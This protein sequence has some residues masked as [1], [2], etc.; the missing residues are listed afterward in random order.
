MLLIEHP[1]L[2]TT[3]SREARWLRDEVLGLC[4]KYGTVNVKYEEFTSKLIEQYS[5]IPWERA[6]L[7]V[8]AKEA[9]K[10][11]CRRTS[12]AFYTK[13]SKKAG[14]DKPTW[15]RG[16]VKGNRQK[17]VNWLR[18][19]KFDFDHDWWNEVIG[20]KRNG[21]VLPIHFDRVHNEFVEMYTLITKW[22]ITDFSTKALFRIF[23]FTNKYS[24]DLISKCM[25]L[26]EDPSKRS[27]EYLVPIIE[28]EFTIAKN[29]LM[30]R[31]EL[32]SQSKQILTSILETVVSEREAVDWD[33]VEESIQV[34]TENAKMFNKVKLS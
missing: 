27:I 33:M 28:K 26:V 23:N 21:G 22:L 6:V 24:T 5:P 16:S 8:E 19:A 29:Q 9:Y 10:G 31:K 4:I 15:E 12:A 1:K 20:F 13:K 18:I 25:E 32:H 34:S 30:E 3:M 2:N 7:F 17:N 14:V 11:V